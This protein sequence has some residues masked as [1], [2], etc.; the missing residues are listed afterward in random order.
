MLRGLT[1]SGSPRLVAR[2][3]DQRRWRPLWP[4][5]AVSRMPSAPE[6]A[7]VFVPSWAAVSC[8]HDTGRTAAH[9]GCSFHS[10]DT[11]SGRRLPLAL[12]SSPSRPHSPQPPRRWL[13]ATS[14][15]GGRRGT[16]ETPQRMRRPRPKFACACRCVAWYLIVWESKPRVGGLPRATEFHP[17]WPGRSVR[18]SSRDTGL[19]LREPTRPAGPPD[20][21]LG[22]A[23]AR[24]RVTLTAL[25]ADARQT[26][27]RHVVRI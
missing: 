25:P 10:L 3:A 1:R 18:P 26:S 4:G 6:F 24:Q 5:S 22:S 21:S 2:P 19:W 20:T 27:G 11:A 7:S 12:V 14:H 13:A 15:R 23:R 8:T 17:T 9:S 16:R